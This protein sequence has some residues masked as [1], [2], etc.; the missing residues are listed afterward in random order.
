MYTKVNGEQQVQILSPNFS[1]SPSNED[2]VLNISANGR[3]F[4]PLFAV[5]AGVT[6]LVSNVAPG[7]YYKL[8]G[9]QSQVVINWQRM[10]AT[11]GGGGDSTELQPVADFPLNAVEGTVISY[12]GSSSAS[13]VYQFDGTE[14]T[15]V[16]SD[17]D[18]SAYWTSAQTQ[19]AI[20]EVDDHLYDVERV[21]ASALTVLHDSILELSGS[22]VD[23]SAYWTSAQ[24]QS[25]I[26]QAISGIDLSNYYTIA[27][28]E[29]AITAA[30]A[31]MVS[32][33]SVSTIWRGSQA[34]YDAIT[35][36]DPNTFYIIV[37]N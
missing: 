30:T 13:G 21:T 7:S 14:W 18:L 5:S 35:T 34:D 25:A 4:S 29:N 10:C 23:L 33:T 1:I 28:T 31:N 26:T 15:E 27:Q 19:S 24:T 16:G 11:D 22:S 36:K 3:D 9:N 37:N 8:V 20:T 32:S 2:Y 17:V 12:T 6:R